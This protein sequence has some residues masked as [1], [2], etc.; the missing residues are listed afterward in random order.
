VCHREG[1]GP[2]AE[3]SRRSCARGVSGRA[4]RHSDMA[5]EIRTQ[6]IVEEGTVHRLVQTGAVRAARERRFARCETAPE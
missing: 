1:G 2:A 5:A 4:N 6:A 3:E